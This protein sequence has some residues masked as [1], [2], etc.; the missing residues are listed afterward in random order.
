MIDSFTTR[1]IKELVAASMPE[2]V[3]NKIL[4]WDKEHYVIVAPHRNKLD[5]LDP[6][7]SVN[8]HN[9]EIRPFY[10]GENFLKFAK[11]VSKS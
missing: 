3:V 1:R 4:D 6:Y 5:E 8:K 9:G 2:L 10:V 11:V 7:Y